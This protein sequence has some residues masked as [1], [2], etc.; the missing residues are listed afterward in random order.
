MHP[1]A[2][3]LLAVAQVIVLAQ[4][5]GGAGLGGEGVEKRGVEGHCEYIEKKMRILCK[6]G[7]T[8]TKNQC[9][10]SSTAKGLVHTDSTDYTDFID[11]VPE[12][13]DLSFVTKAPLSS[14]IIYTLFAYRTAETYVQIRQNS[15]EIKSIVKLVFNI[16]LIPS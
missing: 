15:N 4:A 5:G 11:L 14:Y 2:S 9:A 1:P 12:G 13:A 6:H 16:P 8:D 7:G 3:V 10:C